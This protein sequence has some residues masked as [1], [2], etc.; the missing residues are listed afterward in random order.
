MIAATT[1]S[2]RFLSSPLF[3]VALIACAHAASLGSAREHRLAVGAEHACM[4]D[5]AGAV[6]C[7]G[8]NEFG[9]I[10]DGSYGWAGPGGA[11]RKTSTDRP[12][13]VRVGRTMGR[14]RGIF[15]GSRNTCAVTESGMLWCWG[16]FEGDIRRDAYHP[17]PRLRDLGRPVLEVSVGSDHACALRDDGRVRCWGWNLYGQLGT[18]TTDDV[19]VA[20][21]PLPSRP[22]IAWTDS[23]VTIRVG[24]DFTCA[25]EGLSGVSCV[26]DNRDGQLG[27]PT[28]DR[29]PHP[30]RVPISK[31][32][33]LECSGHR[34]CALL[35]D[36]SL[37]CWGGTP[38]LTN[39]PLPAGFPIREFRL[40]SDH[41]FL[42]DTAGSVF[43]LGEDLPRVKVPLPAP[44]RELDARETH[45]CALL[46]D[47]SVWCWGSGR[48]FRLDD[49]DKVDGPEPYRIGYRPG[50]SKR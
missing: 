2:F 41:L 7:W 14:V 42:L 31:A 9:Q 35:A 20:P 24:A 11:S 36:D 44:A 18:D 48:Q 43:E 21:R 33:E 32:R 49:P 1:P 45:A 27:H 3:L 16:D 39:I 50:A 10:G 47:E 28:P 4:V 17:A 13:P 40:A 25:D 38:G 26:G 8:T 12:A 5:T 19:L 29:S 6:W 22:S 15:A 46:Q 30:S 37:V 34:A 23:V